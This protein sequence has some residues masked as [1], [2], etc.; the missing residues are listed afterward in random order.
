MVQ[1]ITKVLTGVFLFALL[2]AGV[3]AQAQSLTADDLG[4]GEGSAAAGIG[5]GGG[6]FQEILADV[7]RTFMS[8]LGI[9]AVMVILYGGFKWMTS[10]GDDSK[11]EKARKL[12]INGAIGLVIILLSYAI[13]QFVI[14][15]IIT[16][17]TQ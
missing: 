1:R 6:D 17:T 4:I 3:P 16:R 5:L 8:F 15:E 7:V 2:V 12:I 11:V 10:G 13:V 14:G 9:I